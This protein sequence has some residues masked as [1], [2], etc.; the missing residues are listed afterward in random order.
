M[1]VKEQDNQEINNENE[2][3][4]TPSFVVREVGEEV[5]SNDFEENEEEINSDNSEKSIQNDDTPEDIEEEVVENE[6]EDEY[7][8]VELNEE[9]A[10]KF[11]KESRGLDVESVDE[12]LNPKGGKK[13]SATAEKFQEFI[14]KTGND[15]ISDFLATQKDWSKEEPENV[16]KQ[17]LKTENPTLD[18]EE[19]DFLY[20]EKYAYDE[21]S[22]DDAEKTRKGINKKVDLQ[23]ALTFLEK[24]KEEYMIQR[25]SLDNIP[26]DYLKAKQLVDN[27]NNEISQIEKESAIKRNGFVSATESIFNESF[28]GFETKIG[29]ESF[30]VKPADISKTKEAQMDIRN[31][32][33]KFFDENENLIDPV[34]YH[35]ALYF[36]M[37]ADKMAEHYFNLGKANQAELDEKESKNIPETNGVRTVTKP[38]GSAN[39]KVREV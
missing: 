1:D 22:Y 5:V 17:L 6:E 4:E 12:L 9:E 25:G 8:T 37:N 39:F 23:K 24:Q 38:I 10:F 3:K 34:G 2:V 20:K 18:K 14:D 7:E 13:L 15:N 26:E 36:A 32:Q 27:Y 21:E 35:K 19:I 11:L 33:S 31:F 30:V 29:E 28:K 16:L